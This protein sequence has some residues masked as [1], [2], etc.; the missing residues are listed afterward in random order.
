MDRHFDRIRHIHVNEM[1]GSYPRPG[2]GHDFQPVLRVLRDRGYRGWVSMEVFDFQP[3]AEK[4]V[5]EA[6]AYLQDQ[7][8]HLT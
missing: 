7:I 5:T 2:G 3:G 6:G 4:I 1:D 8:A